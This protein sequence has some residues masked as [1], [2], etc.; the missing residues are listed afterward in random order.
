M[1]DLALGREFERR[2]R[3]DWL[4]LAT[5]ALAGGD[6]GGLLATT[7]ADGIRLAAL[8]ARDDLGDLE[9]CGLPGCPPFTRGF[10][11]ARNAPGWDIC[12]LHADPD[13]ARANTAILEDLAGGAT[14][15]VLRMSAPGQ[16]GLPA[17]LEAVRTALAGVH[18]EMIAV[19]LEAGEH[20][21]GAAQS[22]LALWDESGIA[23]TVRRGSFNAD[24]LGA[25]A[26]TGALEDRLYDAIRTLAHFVSGNLATWPGIRFLLADGRP[27]HEAGGSDAQ[28]LAAV[29]ATVVAYLRAL[30]EEGTAPHKVFAGLEVAVSAECDLFLAIAKIRAMRGLIW[31]MAEACGAGERARSVSIRVQT[32]ERMMARR[33][34]HVNMLRTTI[35][36]AAAALGGADALTV[37]PFTWALGRT[38]KLARRMARNTHLV[39]QEESFLDRVLDPA[40]GSW[41]V[42]HLSDALQRRA[43][44]LFQEIEARRGMEEV[45]LD[46]WLAGGIADVAEKRARALARG[47]AD[48]T[49]ITSFPDLSPTSLE[50][51]PHPAAMAHRDGGERVRRLQPR[52][53]A[54][55]FERL[56]DAS[57]RYRARTGHSPKVFLIPLGG[58][59]KVSATTD[60]ARDVFAIAGIEVLYADEMTGAGSEAS[61]S[62]ATRAFSE[63]GAAIACICAGPDW[64]GDD[65]RTLGAALAEAGAKRVFACTS[66]PDAAD[67]IAGEVAIDGHVY[68]GCDRF[69]ILE[70]GLTAYGYGDENS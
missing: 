23:D 30:E 37:L 4:D 25:L 33:D 27:Y 14:S 2:S 26:R 52:R 56:R 6:P 22:L 9:D 70:C 55:P 51:E 41:Y 7:T 40:G 34:P 10:H 48:L 50:V 16:F 13:P 69:E 53:L 36:A 17:R 31:R 66:S 18:L 57:D 5:R 32:S 19:G 35:A 58:A 44:A 61:I 49:S 65:A 29:L 54:K 59:S 63:S 21:L 67:D 11:Q 46:G 12:Q 24:P 28:E 20:Y 42:E 1:S 64:P 39:L 15:I 3:R 38:G 68:P 60:L 45:L 8:Y 43:W 47:D 62:P